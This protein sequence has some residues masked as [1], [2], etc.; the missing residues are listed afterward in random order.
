MAASAKACPRLA[1]LLR[2]GET[3]KPVLETATSLNVKLGLGRSSR[4]RMAA[5]SRPGFGISEA[6]DSKTL[7]RNS[8]GLDTAT[9]LKLT[10][11]LGGRDQD[12]YKKRPF[13]KQ[14][15]HRKHDREDEDLGEEAPRPPRGPNVSERTQ[16]RVSGHQAV[17]E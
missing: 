12:G 1:H 4:G 15:E 2:F 16:P 11:P 5:W 8:L 17:G 14:G 7:G 10:I 6:A 13:A 3:E 9:S